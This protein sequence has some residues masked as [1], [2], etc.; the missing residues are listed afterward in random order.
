[1][2]GV[3]ARLLDRRRSVGCPMNA[4]RQS[5]CRYGSSNRANPGTQTLQATLIMIRILETPSIANFP[6]PLTRDMRRGAEPM[7]LGMMLRDPALSLFRRMNSLFREKN[8]L[9]RA[10]QGIACNAAEWLH[11]L[12]SEPAKRAQ[13]GSELCGFPVNFPVLREL[14]VEP[15]VQ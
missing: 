14:R 9:F 11:K 15:G 8:S 10:L 4:E 5:D 1:M 2:I 3:G 7:R 6:Q 13:N 12:T